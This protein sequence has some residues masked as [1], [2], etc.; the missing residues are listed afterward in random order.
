MIHRKRKRV[1]EGGERTWRGIRGRDVL[2]QPN[3]NAKFLHIGRVRIVR[4][5]D[6]RKREGDAGRHL[7]R[8]TP[9]G[10]VPECGGHLAQRWEP[11]SIRIRNGRSEQ[12]APDVPPCGSLSLSLSSPFPSSVAFVYSPSLGIGPVGFPSSLS[13]R[14]FLQ[15]PLELCGESFFRIRILGGVQGGRHTR[16]I[17]TPLLLAFHVFAPSLVMKNAGRTKRRCPYPLDEE[18]VVVVVPASPRSAFPSS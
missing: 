1:D 5:C 17:A 9:R 6:A 18:E 8:M 12:R 11:F 2:R 13:M 14:G 15:I 16:H 4:K 7:R 3:V 10:R